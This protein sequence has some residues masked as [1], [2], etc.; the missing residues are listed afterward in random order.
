MANKWKQS[1]KKIERI[2]VIGIASRKITD[3]MRI[4][5]SKHGGIQLRSV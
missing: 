3:E 4:I 1:G 5:A 2:N